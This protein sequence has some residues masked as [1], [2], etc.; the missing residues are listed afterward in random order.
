MRSSEASHA[1]VF[2]TRKL[3]P[4]PGSE[5]EGHSDRL[6]HEVHQ[7]LIAVH[8]SSGGLMLTRCST[9]TRVSIQRDG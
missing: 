3:R 8:S 1:L 4:S 7:Q 9:L 2:S 5:I 6:R